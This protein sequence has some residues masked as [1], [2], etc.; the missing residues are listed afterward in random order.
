MLLVCVKNFV[1]PGT[2]GLGGSTRLLLVFGRMLP[3]SVESILQ[4]LT[5]CSFRIKKKKKTVLFL[6]DKT[7]HLS[8]VKRGYLLNIG[9]RQ[10]GSAASGSIDPRWD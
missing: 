6:A 5:N 4:F 3:R 2:C 7:K 9:L 10:T 8:L 1:Q